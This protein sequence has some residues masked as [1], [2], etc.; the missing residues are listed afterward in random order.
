MALHAFIEHLKKDHE[1]QKKL[2][3]QLVEADAPAEREQLRK[4]LYEAL[5][6]HMKGEEASIF[7]RL[8]RTD[9]DND[10]FQAREGLQE[11]YVARVV[12]DE[13]MELEPNSDVFSAK[14]KVLD[15]IN[16][17]HIEEEEEDVLER[18]EKICS[19][20]ELDT[21]FQTYKTAEHAARNSRQ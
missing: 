1:K 19:T 18:L 3:Q 8:K 15:E 5:Y 21:H 6:P 7:P 13:L 10:T 2:G 4:A 11:H 16:R 17:H 9:S 20:E 12:L 14:A